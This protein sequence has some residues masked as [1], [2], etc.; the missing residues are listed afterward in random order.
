MRSDL[1]NSLLIKSAQKLKSGGPGCLLL[2]GNVSADLSRWPND[3][4]HAQGL[5]RA[6]RVGPWAWTVHAETAAGAR[7]RSWALRR[8]A[9]RHGP[10]TG[11]I[12]TVVVDFA[13]L[14]TAVLATSVF[15]R[16]SCG[17]LAVH[18]REVAC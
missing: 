9:G 15:A 6:F 17:R 18:R 5:V 12:E 2:K 8:G 10:E 11:R 14:E 13:A 1:K 3:T 7:V 16:T 4:R